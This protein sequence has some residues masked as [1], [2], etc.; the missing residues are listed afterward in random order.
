[1]K[2]EVKNGRLLISLKLRKKPK[3]SHSG[4]T[5]VLATTRGVR[6]SSVEI[7]NR[8]VRVTANAFIDADYSKK[9]G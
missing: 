9:T 1:M 7:A 6:T 8:P 2:V 4:K 3:P 5:L